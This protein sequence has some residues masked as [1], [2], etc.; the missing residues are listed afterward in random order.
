MIICNHVLEHVPNDYQALQEC[1]RVLRNGGVAVFTIPGDFSSID[2]KTTTFEKP[3]GNGH[4]RHYGMDVVDMMRATFKSVAT[5][6]MSITANPQ[7]MV[8]LGDYAFVCTK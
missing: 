6:D 3:D 2:T 1:H 4:Y 5:L 7:W 8:R